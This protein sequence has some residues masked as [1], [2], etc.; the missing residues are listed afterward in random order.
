MTRFLFN[1]TIE[2]SALTEREA[3]NIFK[4]KYPG[5]KI[6][7]SKV[8][9]NELYTVNNA[10]NIEKI[11]MYN[12]DNNTYYRFQSKF[13]KIGNKSWE[14]G[15]DSEEEALENDARILN[16]KSCCSAAK[17]LHGF[18]FEFNK[19]YHVL[20]L[21]GDFIEIGHDDED[22]IDVAKILEIWSYEEFCKMVSDI[23]M[24]LYDDE[25]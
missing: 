25:E 17:S 5:V 6:E 7:N 20:V 12:A 24:G 22:V 13:L 15:Y 23:K 16:G 8:I 4:V 21:T 9:R 19:D 1:N 18:R 14:M 10:P 3:N 11:K 2:I